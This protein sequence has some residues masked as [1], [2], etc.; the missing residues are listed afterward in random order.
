M[1]VW[2]SHLCACDSGVDAISMECY[3]CTLKQT[4]AKIFNSSEFPNNI[5]LFCCLPKLARDIESELLVK[6]QY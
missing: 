1:H 2:K 3:N 5:A 6:F 4:A